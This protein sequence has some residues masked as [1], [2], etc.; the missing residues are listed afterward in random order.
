MRNEELQEKKRKE[1][2]KKKKRK[3]RKYAFY[4]N[5]KRCERYDKSFLSWRKLF[6][7]MSVLFSFSDLSSKGLE[8]NMAGLS[9]FRGNQIRL[10]TSPFWDR[11]VP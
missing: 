7:E 8:K 6:E 3:K 2:K 11:Q 5:V 9:N 4:R 1:K 10:Q